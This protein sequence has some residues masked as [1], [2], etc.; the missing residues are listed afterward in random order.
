MHAE[1]YEVSASAATSIV[2]AKQSQDPVVAVGTT[3]VRT[4]EAV[5]ERHGQVAASSGQTDIFITPGWRF[6]VVDQLIT[7]FHLPRSTLLMLVSALLGRQR[8]LD[9][10]DMAL[11]RG[12]RFYS[13]GDGMWV[14]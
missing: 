14:R 13:Y 12:Y 8:T 4:L 3:V 5:A 9:A 10:Y 6:R 1:R 11:S 7:N 2:E